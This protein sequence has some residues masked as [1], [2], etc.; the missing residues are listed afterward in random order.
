M[1][2]KDEFLDILLA[3]TGRAVSG[4]VGRWVNCEP[5][6][7]QRI[8]FA[9]HSSHLDILVL[10]ASLPP[11]VRRLTRPAAAKDYWDKTPFR[12]YLALKVF[13]AI[14]IERREHGGSLRS[15]L[16]SVE[17]TVAGLGDRH[18]LIIFPEGTRREG[19]EVGPFKTGIFHLAKRIPGI[20]LVP[21]YMENLNRI[22]PKGEFFPVPL[23]SSISFGPPLTLGDSESK[24][25]FVKRAR[26]AV[27][28][29]GDG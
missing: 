15:A 14:L 7:R 12:R 9:N 19:H 23:L 10:W 18:S 13:N 2:R 17:N 5:S 22:L 29:L 1:T 4:T 11:D 20:E 16:R 25:D 26:D 28:A 24:H 6:T 21:V 8:Y 3:W 27:I